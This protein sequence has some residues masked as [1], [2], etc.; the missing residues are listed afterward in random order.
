M[1]ELKIDGLY[2][3]KYKDAAYSYVDLLKKKISIPKSILSVGRIRRI[4]PEFIDLGISW[5]KPTESRD[6]KI[7]YCQGIVIPT[8]TIVSIKKLETTHEE[9]V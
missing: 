4:E 7:E 1:K 3:V 8:Q 2:A 9:K 5:I 6:D